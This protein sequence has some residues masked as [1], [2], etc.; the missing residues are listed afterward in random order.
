MDRV[1]VF[2]GSKTPK[3]INDDERKVRVVLSDESVDSDNEVVVQ[4]GIDFKRFKQNPVVLKNHDTGGPQFFGPPTGADPIGKVTEYE[5]IKDGDNERTEAEIQF[6]SEEANPDGYRTYLLIKE[7]IV[8]GISMGFKVLED[9]V[10]KLDGGGQIT[11]LTKTL[12]AEVSVVAIPAN[13]NARIKSYKNTSDNNDVCDNKGMSKEQEQAPATESVESLK[14]A[15]LETDLT[16]A[17]ATIKTLLTALNKKQDDEDQAEAEDEGKDKEQGGVKVDED[18][19][20][21]VEE[22]SPEAEKLYKAY[23]TMAIAEGSK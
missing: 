10:Q 22:N 20:V 9:K 23:R 19:N 4:K 21:V 2:T 8:N 16:E 13:M 3:T 7:G 5:R 15:Q 1:K 6:A 18:G 14:I 17:K 11:Y 12:L